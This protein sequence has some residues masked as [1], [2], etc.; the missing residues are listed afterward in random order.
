M[1]V[2]LLMTTCVSLK[3]SHKPNS[4]LRICIIGNQ[5]FSLL[6]FRG[7]LISD[8]AAKGHEVLALAPDY[9]EKTRN[10]VRALGAEPF[11]FSLSRTGMNPGRDVTDMLRLTFL[12]RQLKPDITLGYAI[13]PVIYGTVAA[14]LAGVPRRIAM[15]EG[16][17]YV[18]T[19]S[20]GEGT[21][22]RRALKSVVSLL[23]AVGLR[24]ADLV[25][26][27]NKDDINEFSKKRLVVTTKAFLLG[28]I[29]IDLIEWQPLPSVIDP[30]TFILVARLLKEKGIVEY[31]KAARII[32]LK[33]PDTRF[34]LLGGLDSNPGALSREEVDTWTG[35][36]ILEWPGHVPDVRLWAA[37]SSIFVLPSY[38]E[39]VPRSTQEM[40]AMARPV[41]TTDAPG[42]RETV[43]DGENGFLVPMRDAEALAAAMERFILNPSLI[44]TMGKA[45]RIIA[46]ERFDVKKINQVILK[47][48]GL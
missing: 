6:N 38:R 9:E 22:K 14:W 44:E 16:L 28:G 26:F 18:F 17:G 11:D 1:S 2:K 4:R 10:E 19:P 39:G 35:E 31:A 12:L 30:V 27:L 29:G 37:K 32:K 3:M 33:Y 7:L 41:I 40:M 5:A 42:C 23:Y 46:E 15:I 43:V 45:S 36:G 24:K 47:E 13:K 48:M 34:V 25:F 21:F 20:E 8:M